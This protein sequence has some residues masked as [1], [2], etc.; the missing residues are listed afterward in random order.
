[1]I[2]FFKKNFLK[3]TIFTFLVKLIFIFWSAHPYDFWT[4]ANTF[5]QNTIY[6]LSI[7][8]S[9]NKGNLLILLWH[10]LYSL[11][12]VI[13]K[14]FS[15][16]PDQLLLLH[17]VFKIPFLLVDLISGFLIYKIV[18]FLYN[19]DDK[20]RLGF[21]MWFLNPLIY[22]VYGIH[23]HY[24]ILIPFS[25]I[26]L[27]LGLLKK[28]YWLIGL[29]L[30]LA[31]TTKYFILLIFPFLVFYFYANKEIKIG[32]KALLVFLAFLLFSYIHFFFD[33]SLVSKNFNSIISLSRANTPIMILEK[34]MPPLNLFSSIN[35]ILGLA[36]ISNLKNALLFNISNRGIFLILIILFFH[37]CYRFILIF[38]KKKDYNILTFIKDV[39]LFLF[40]FLVLIGNFQIHYLSWLVPLLILLIIDNENL[41]WSF[42]SLTVVGSIYSLKN[43]LGART[44][45]LDIFNH[46]TPLALNDASITSKY[47]TGE[48]IVLFILSSA[49]ILI[50]FDKKTKNIIN[51]TAYFKFVAL[52]WIF[53]F[54]IYTQVIYSFILYGLDNNSI[55]F[56]R[57]VF[58]RG[59]IFATYKIDKIHDGTLFFRNDNI[60]KSSLI[61][62]ITD[63]KNI[64]KNNFRV[65]LIIKNLDRGNIIKSYLVGAKFNQCRLGGYRSKIFDYVDNN[66]YQG[67]DIDINCISQINNMIITDDYTGIINED[68]LELYITNINSH[69]LYDYNNDNAIYLSAIIGFVYLLFI[70]KISI[71]ILKNFTRNNSKL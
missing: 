66:L 32:R 18:N 52:L 13:L 41:L 4:F 63:N 38:Y 26:I 12:L 40:Y 48:F 16:P 33:F 62:E 34:K 29:S 53:I 64:N 30:G 27:I 68:D 22:Y 54:I 5:Q 42:I 9:W 47:V 56:S 21:L 61:P 51:V 37:F 43:E 60:Y 36:P 6:N 67:F 35:N 8:G 17:F 1:M 65:F 59:I 31:F 23:G 46:F 28:N 11:Y 3:I 20:A 2:E 44:F 49:I 57:G 69:S 70:F 58:H 25:I 19:D 71:D 50:F 7:F 15:I 10:P 24:E 39:L 45:F 14:M 55:A